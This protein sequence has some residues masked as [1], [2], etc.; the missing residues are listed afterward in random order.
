MYLNSL[1]T[2]IKSKILGSNK[3]KIAKIVPLVDK[4]YIPDI[5]IGLSEVEFYKSIDY[6]TSDSDLYSKSN[7]LYPE[8]CDSYSNEVGID[9]NGYEKCKIIENYV[10]FM[11]IINYLKIPYYKRDSIDLCFDASS[12]LNGLYNDRVSEHIAIDIV[13]DDAIDI[14]LNLCSSNVI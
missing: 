9:I 6:Q 2:N 10:S 1:I 13:F 7:G 11:D 4:E 12:E 3:P 8:K 5:E 14:P